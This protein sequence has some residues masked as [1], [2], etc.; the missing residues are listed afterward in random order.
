MESPEKEK[1]EKGIKLKEKYRLWWEYFM[2]SGLYKRL[3]EKARNYFLEG[4][5]KGWE[6]WDKALNEEMEREEKIEK[7]GETKE[8]LIKHS[9]CFGN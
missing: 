8:K 1:K 4:W 3:E 6:K 9:F 5:E 2:R 7:G